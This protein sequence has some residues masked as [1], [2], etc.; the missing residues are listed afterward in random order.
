MSDEEE[1]KYEAPVIRNPKDKRKKFH[2][3][4]KRIIPF[5]TAD[6]KNHE[7]WSKNRNLANFP[8]PSKILLIGSPNCGKTVVAQNIILRSRPMYDNVYVCMEHGSSLE[9]DE[10]NP[11]EFL[12]EIPP[13]NFFDP[14]KKNLIVLEDWETDKR[15]SNLSKLFRVT[16][17]HCKTSIML[18]Y[19]SFFRT[20]PLARRLCDVYVVWKLPDRNELEMIAR[21]VGYN[22]KQFLELFD[23]F[24]KT[25]YD[26]ITF[27]LTSNSPAPLRFNVFQPIRKQIK[28]NM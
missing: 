10:I 12:T 26:N 27:D 11:T 2:K 24:C 15:D 4:P 25:K 13:P 22:T 28:I 23:T 9:W 16:S 7:K 14:D 18:L 17:S 19:Q 1:Y 21:R 6:K 20:I 3:L 8:A 5:V